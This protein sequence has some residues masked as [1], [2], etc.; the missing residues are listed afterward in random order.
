MKPNPL[1]TTVSVIRGEIG[2]TQEEFARL[3]DKSRIT[4]QSIEL[5]KLNLSKGLALR[6]AQETGVALPWLLDE[7]PDEPPWA[8]AV[9][10]GTR[11]WTKA[12]YE[13]AQARKAER[14]SSDYK[15]DL[16]EIIERAKKDVQDWPAIVSSAYAKGEGQVCHFLARQF[17]ADMEK[18]FGKDTKNFDGKWVKVRPKK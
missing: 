18:R 11:P 4:V 7:K 17:M 5:G 12:D 8:W 2:I 13:R 3:I 1:R 9:G 10:G 14:T 16:F 6:I 15:P